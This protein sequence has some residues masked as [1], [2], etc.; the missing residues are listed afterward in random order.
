MNENH[1]HQG[2]QQRSTALNPNAA[3]FVPRQQQ[4]SVPPQVLAEPPPHLN[5]RNN[6]LLRQPALLPNPADYQFHIQQGNNPMQFPQKNVGLQNT[7]QNISNWTLVVQ[8]RPVLMSQTQTCHDY[9][10]RYPSP[11]QP[12]LQYSAP[13]LQDNQQIWMNKPPRRMV[14]N[15]TH[16]QSESTMINQP[17]C[18]RPP[19]QPIAHYPQPVMNSNQPIRMGR[20]SYCISANQA[21]FQ[22]EFL[23]PNHHRG[24]PSCRT[25]RSTGGPWMQLLKQEQELL[26]T[27]SCKGVDIFKL[28]KGNASR[29]L[30]NQFSQNTSGLY[31]TGKIL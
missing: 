7:P 20:P 31:K 15:L 16:F 22:S 9:L 26:Q 12:H 6:Q 18:S 28:C 17:R 14:S 29:T 25:E 4:N 11:L 2:N 10:G 13:I 24:S 1:Q 21:P 30:L 23:G 5:P 8:G 27:K 19:L 3:H